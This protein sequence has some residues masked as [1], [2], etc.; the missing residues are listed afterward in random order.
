MN[1]II[2]HS[3]ESVLQIAAMF[4]KQHEPPLIASIT[5]SAIF[6]SD[7]VYMDVVEINYFYVCL[8]FFFSIIIIGL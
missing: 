3:S 7:N 2:I 1:L 8:H 5:I 4:L 6:T